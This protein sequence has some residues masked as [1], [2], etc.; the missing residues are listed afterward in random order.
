[1]SFDAAQQQLLRTDA[2]FWRPLLEENYQLLSNAIGN[3]DDLMELD[4]AG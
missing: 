1:V 3:M 4:L 2:F